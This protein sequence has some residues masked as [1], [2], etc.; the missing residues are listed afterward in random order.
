MYT[1]Y[2]YAF[3]KEHLIPDMSL[4]KQLMM[5]SYQTTH[6]KTSFLLEKKKKKTVFIFDWGTIPISFS[7][8]LHFR[9]HVF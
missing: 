4:G 8:E 6:N 7:Q 2:F 1:M 9:A 5:R 3:F